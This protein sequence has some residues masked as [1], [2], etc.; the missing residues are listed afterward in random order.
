MSKKLDLFGISA[1][2]TFDRRFEV[3]LSRYE[4][5]FIN[6]AS[7]YYQDLKI[8]YHPEK[9][10]S[11]EELH[12]SL[13]SWYSHPGSCLFEIS[14]VPNPVLKSSGGVIQLV[15]F[16]YSFGMVAFEKMTVLHNFRICMTP[17]HFLPPSAPESHVRLMFRIS[18]HTDTDPYIKLT[19]DAN[20]WK[21]F[22]RR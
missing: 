10:L 3:H 15:N 6:M 9:P 17:F 16:Y 1:T 11:E 4:A 20:T 8:P 19:M 21:N 7:I 22:C 5:F 12:P 2:T 13:P 18:N 14:L